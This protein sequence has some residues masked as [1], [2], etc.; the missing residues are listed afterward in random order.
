MTINTC[1]TEN[2][3]KD[4]YALVLQAAADTNQA[5]IESEEIGIDTSCYKVAMDKLET[6]K[7]RLLDAHADAMQ[8]EYL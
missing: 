1:L 8:K 2:E 3:W 4:M 5:I 7:Q 6:L